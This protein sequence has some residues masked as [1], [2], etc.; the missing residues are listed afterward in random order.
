M[1][2]IGMHI[3][4]LDSLDRAVDRAHQ[5]GCNT[6]QIFTRNP[7]G[8]VYRELKTDEVEA[9][10]MKRELTKIDP[11]FAHT[12][13]LTN[14]SSP[15][16]TVYWRSVESVKVELMRCGM[17][18]IPFVVTHLGSHLGLGKSEGRKRVISA[19]N[20]SLLAVRNEVFL[21][22]ENSAGTRNSVGSHLREVGEIIMN[23]EDEERVGFCFDTCHGYAAG[24]DLKTTEGVENTIDEIDSLIGFEKL[25]VVH[26]NDSK[27]SLGSRV[28][29]HEHI[30]LGRIGEEGFVNI[31]RSRLSEVP[32][33][34]ETPVDNRRSDRE[35]LAKVRELWERA[36]KQP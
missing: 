29:R 2:K 14:L 35:N 9:F 11:A 12:P 16:E 23:L 1:L 34:L 10:K 13:Y 32:L 33:I 7:R 20:D 5:V 4:I 18:G 27:G 36:Q 30:G 3:S 21:L 22:L 15:R 25:R 19:I 26:L 31:L 8:W 17:L 6:L 24:Y 28:D